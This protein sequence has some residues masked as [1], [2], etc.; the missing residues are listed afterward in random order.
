MDEQ[1]Q[2]HVNEELSYIQEFPSEKMYEHDEIIPC[3]LL[4]F[5]FKK[6]LIL[7]SVESDLELP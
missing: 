2:T 4:V 6:V 5:L 7:T 1:T 3:G